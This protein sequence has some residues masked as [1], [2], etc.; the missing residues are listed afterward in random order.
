MAH[1]NGQVCRADP[2]MAWELRVAMKEMVSDIRD[3][4]ERRECG[5][6]QHESHVNNAIST[7]DIDVAEHQADRA[8]GVERSVGSRERQYPIRS[9]DLAFEIDQPNEERCDNG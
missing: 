4:K 8:Q 6:R 7:R 9:D 2:T 3:Q 1:Q 5:C